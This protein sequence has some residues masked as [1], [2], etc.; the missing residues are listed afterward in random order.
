MARLVLSLVILLL[1]VAA[2]CDASNDLVVGRREEGDELIQSDKVKLLNIIPLE[3]VTIVKTYTG[4]NASLI[5][6]IRAMDLD[7]NNRG[8]NA[9]IIAGGIGDKFVTIKFTSRKSILPTT[10]DFKVDIYGLKVTK[11]F[12]VNSDLVVE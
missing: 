7:K 4:D 6:Y 2:Y 10:I 3:V 12:D 1:A 11:V 8:A 9:A 5:T